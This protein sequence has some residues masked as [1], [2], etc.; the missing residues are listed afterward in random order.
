MDYKQ[1]FI[2]VMNNKKDPQYQD[3]LLKFKISKNMHIF[4]NKIKN[5][6]ETEQ[7]KIKLQGFDNVENVFANLKNVKEKL[8]SE[9]TKRKIKLDNIQKKRKE[10]EKLLKE[11]KTKG[12]EAQAVDLVVKSNKSPLEKEENLKKIKPLLTDSAV[13]QA[14]D[15]T[16]KKIHDSNEKNKEKEEKMIEKKNEK[17]E[18]NEEKLEEQVKKL[19]LKKFD[20]KE[21]PIAPP[22][23]LVNRVTGKID[24]PVA[25][26]LPPGI[27]QKESPFTKEIKLEEDYVKDIKFYDEKENKIKSLKDIY[28][29]RIYEKIMN[30]NKLNFT[31]NDNQ[32]QEVIERMAKKINKTS[33]DDNKN[34]EDKQKEIENEWIT[35]DSKCSNRLEKLF[36]QELDLTAYILRVL[37]ASVIDTSEGKKYPIVFK[38]YENEIEKLEGNWENDKKH[39][40]IYH[41]EKEKDSEK[42]LVYGFG[43]SASGKTYWAEKIINLMQTTNKNISK[44]F[45]SIDGGIVREQ[46]VMYR[47]VVEI[48]HKKGLGFKNLVVAGIGGVFAHSMFSASKIKKKLIEYL[49]STITTDIKLSLYIPETASNVKKVKSADKKYKFITGDQK[50][51]SLLIWQ[52]I[53]EQEYCGKSHRF[54]GG[55]GSWKCMCDF[56]QGFKCVGTKVSGELRSN[57]EGKQYDP[58]A[59]KTSMK[60]GMEML[61]ISLGPRIMIHNSGAPENK[62]TIIE[63]GVAGMYLLDNDKSQ[64]KIKEYGG[65]YKK[66]SHDD[67]EIKDPKKE[68]KRW[69]KERIELD[70]K[71]LLNPIEK[72]IMNEHLK[73]G[74]KQDETTIESLQK[75]KPDMKLIPIEQKKQQVK[76]EKNKKLQEAM[77][78]VDDPSRKEH[79]KEEAALPPPAVPA[80]TSDMLP[81]PSP[82]E[83]RKS[84]KEKVKKKPPPPPKRKAPTRLTNKGGKKKKRKRTRKKKRS[85]K[86]KK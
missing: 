54:F 45:I 51:T 75:K 12:V 26:P 67:K 66:E 81:P 61:R 78:K 69:N 11:K 52:H 50:P 15:D 48:A 56:Q 86:K 82:S 22:P 33:N 21:E 16:V 63:E 55:S 39:I 17:I 36:K 83:A 18:K 40:Q 32:I 37:S 44:S 84:L 19:N 8:A 71:G 28:N 80:L 62:S 9:S 72:E 31:D 77:A 14:T 35:C 46:S 59:W 64:E 53:N 58:I 76:D 7:L 23:G 68:K 43:P 42:K 29:G 34:E 24:N 38:C 3:A 47:H 20:D 25:Q 4:T 30:M 6:I 60:N 85:R 27:T 10:L 73:I 79:R 74:K 13:K 2:N 1:E 49:E 41:H 5:I 70:K 65:V 57:E